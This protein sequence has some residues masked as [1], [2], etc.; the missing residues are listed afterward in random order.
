MSVT[1][2][3]EILG[4]SINVT[5]KP[6]VKS[7]CDQ[8]FQKYGNSFECTANVKKT[9]DLDY[10]EQKISSADAKVICDQM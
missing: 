10:K 4:G 5:D 8:F 2:P 9:G 1:N 6:A 3:P 7:R